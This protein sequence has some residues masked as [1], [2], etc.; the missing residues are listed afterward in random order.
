MARQ[1]PAIPE[2]SFTTDATVGVNTTQVANAPESTPRAVTEQLLAAAFCPSLHRQ[3]RSTEYVAGA[4][5]AL[6]QRFV[7]K[8]FANPHQEGSAAADA[9][10]AGADEGRRLHAD[11][12]AESAGKHTVPESGLATA[13]AVFVAVLLLLGAALDMAALRS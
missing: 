10:F 7:G 9:F 12:V 6:L 8:P 11:Y 2:H 13:L 3:A 1:S 4:R 5:A